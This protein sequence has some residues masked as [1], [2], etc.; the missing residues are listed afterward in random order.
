MVVKSL[1]TEE[2]L[3]NYKRNCKEKF[4]KKNEL[5]KYIIYD[6]TYNVF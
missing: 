2:Y 3:Q 6:R 1:V 4:K 5:D